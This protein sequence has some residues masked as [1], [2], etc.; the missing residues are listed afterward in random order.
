VRIVG[1]TGAVHIAEL[2]GERYFSRLSERRGNP[3]TTAD[4]G[5]MSVDD[6]RFDAVLIAGKS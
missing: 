3:Q 1:G 5:E 4:Y 2:V 6:E